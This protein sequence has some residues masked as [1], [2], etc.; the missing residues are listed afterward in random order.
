YEGLDEKAWNGVSQYSLAYL[1]V[2]FWLFAIYSPIT[3]P[4]HLSYNPPDFFLVLFP[5]VFRKTF[6]FLR[7]EV[8]SGYYKI[9]ENVV[10]HK[11]IKKRLICY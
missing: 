10:K 5:H 2:I 1:A 11:E 8:I 3:L 7:E 4:S 6:T 9:S